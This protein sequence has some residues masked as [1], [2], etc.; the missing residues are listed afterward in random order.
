MMLNKKGW[1]NCF[2]IAL[3]M[4]LIVLILFSI[5]NFYGLEE[6]PNNTREFKTT[7]QVIASEACGE[8]KIGMYLVANTI[9][10][11]AE[12]WAKTPHEIVTQPNQYYGLTSPNRIQ[13]YNQ[14]K[15]FSDELASNILKLPDITDGA[16]Y[17]L[18]PNEEKRSWHKIETLRYKNHIF[19]K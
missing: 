6:K 16:L 19:Y 3:I 13:L 17:F 10:N 9:K 15:D 11:R 1:M 14:C 2:E 4:Q 5:I 8:G 12:Q 18:K 7:S